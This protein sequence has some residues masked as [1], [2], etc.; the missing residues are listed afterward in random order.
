DDRS[1]R[2]QSKGRARR[3]QFLPGLP[4]ALPDLLGP[5][6]GTF[7]DIPKS[8][9]R[10]PNRLEFHRHGKRIVRKVGPDNGARLVS[11]RRSLLS[12]AADSPT[13]S[14]RPS[15]SRPRLAAAD[16]LALLVTHDQ[17][18]AGQLPAQQVGFL[19]G[20]RAVHRGLD[21]QGKRRRRF[22][23]AFQLGLFLFA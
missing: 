19:A 4:L 1:D 17:G 15:G 22:A 3:R 9:P 7:W 16:R 12:P 8:F 6:G 11:A 21:L 14:L 20:R 23:A 18:V 13:V 2:R 10:I 5:S